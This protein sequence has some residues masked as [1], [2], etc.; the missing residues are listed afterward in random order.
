MFVLQIN[1]HTQTLCSLL[2]VHRG[3]VNEMVSLARSEALT[4]PA[5][6][7][8]DLFYE[9][10]ERAGDEFPS[11]V[12]THF[13]QIFKDEDAFNGIQVLSLDCPPITTPSGSLV[14]FR[15]MIQSTMSNE[16]FPLTYEH[17]DMTKLG[18]WGLVDK[19]EFRMDEIDHR[20]STLT[21]RSVYW[22]V[23]VPGESAFITEA[24]DDTRS[25]SSTTDSKPSEVLPELEREIMKAQPH[26]FPTASKHI[27]VQVK[28]YTKDTSAFKPTDI[29][30]FVGLFM[31]DGLGP[32]SL[33]DMNNNKEPDFVPTI[34]V[35]F[36]RLHPKTIA[37]FVY[38][39]R[40]S[41]PS[42][43]AYQVEGY[44]GCLDSVLND[45]T[46][47]I[48]WIAEEAL[49]GDQ[50]AA[51]W[52]ITV[53]V[54][55][56]YSRHPD[57]LPPALTISSF[58]PPPKVATTRPKPTLAHVLALLLPATAFLDLP[59]NLGAW[60]DEGGHV[61]G[62]S[63]AGKPPLPQAVHFAPRSVDE[64]LH[65][66]ALQLAPGTVL[67]V[68]E[69]GVEE[70]VL[71]SQAVENLQTLRSVIRTQ[72]L[73]YKYPFSSGLGFEFHTELPCIVLC[74]GGKTSRSLFLPDNEVTLPLCPK[75]SGG[76]KEYNLYRG[77][78]DIK[79]PPG[80]KLEGFRRLICGAL[81]GDVKVT[82]AVGKYIQADFVKE[83]SE[84][85]SKPS[86]ITP[87]DLRLRM[88][89]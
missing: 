54:A 88:N 3:T 77:A 8:D 68:L 86:T 17:E 27:G 85:A 14:R 1:Q 4:T 59:K 10:G 67:T 62:S 63:E 24:L 46:E 12:A 34:H 75:A 83:R 21:D 78:S 80:D 18:G 7:L 69:A 56:V 58:P 38:P 16:I 47:L 53:A 44:Q 29:V 72:T 66:G 87:D 28:T 84:G 45:R 64:D 50:L 9:Q 42:D 30:T 39:L 70:G 52:V 19:L 76:D 82:Q 5:K 32:P 36:A 25:T 31:I 33:E 81:V 65:S 26:K 57:V 37:P 15:G 11:L 6:A 13:D 60:S 48:S 89:V 73:H 23:S 61:S 40:L 79:L 55:R 2:L 20:D 43:E 74:E 49:G 22:A 35:F 41:T 51:E 71:S